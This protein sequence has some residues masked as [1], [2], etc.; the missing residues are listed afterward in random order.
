MIENKS[1]FIPIG[2]RVLVKP[3]KVEEK[4]AGGIILPDASLDKVKAIMQKAVVIAV[5][6]M[7]FKFDLNGELKTHSDRPSIGE[8]VRI[9]KYAGDEIVGDDDELYKLVNDTDILA[10]ES[11]YE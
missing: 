8:V 11:K 9:I 4:T 7:A 2:S 1:G 5:G 6:D 10:K 3:E